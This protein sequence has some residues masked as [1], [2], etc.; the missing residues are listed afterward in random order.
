MILIYFRMTWLL[1]L[2]LVID[3]NLAQDHKER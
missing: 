1:D 2:F 3:N